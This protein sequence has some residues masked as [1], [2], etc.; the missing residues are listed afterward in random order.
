MLTHTR[1]RLLS[2]LP[3]K[4][5]RGF[6]RGASVV[7]DIPTHTPLT[8]SL[9]TPYSLTP[10]S[11]SSSRPPPQE[12]QRRKTDTRK[13][14][15]IIPIIIIIPIPIS[16]PS[17]ILL[18]KPQP[19]SLSAIITNSFVEPRVLEGVFGGDATFWVVDED[20]AEE[21][22]EGCCEG[23]GGYDDFLEDTGG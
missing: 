22:Q 20:F 8:H 19:Q 11:P 21:V 16:P 2:L 15:I 6:D 1:Q 12:G 5:K 3:Q 23:G 9:T 4:P 10:T 18:R 13:T 17:L 7:S 14:S